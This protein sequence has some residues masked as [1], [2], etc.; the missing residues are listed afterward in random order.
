MIK[1]AGV[2]ICTVIPVNKE[3]II[4]PS[5]AK[6]DIPK[7]DTIAVDSGLVKILVILN[8]IMLLATI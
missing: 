8:E 5:C 6:V 2:V 4:D 3:D 1:V 7:E